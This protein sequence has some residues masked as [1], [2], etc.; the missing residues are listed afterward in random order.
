MGRSL[1][2]AMGAARDPR[3]ATPRRGRDG[4]TMG[5]GVSPKA[6]RPN[7][8]VT[9]PPVAPQQMSGDEMVSMVLA[10]KAQQDQ[11]AVWAH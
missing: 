10:L 5:T 1:S 6:K 3:P 9:P 4:G 8:L 11:V 2:E 7:V